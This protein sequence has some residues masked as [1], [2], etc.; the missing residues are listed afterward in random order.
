MNTARIK[1]ISTMVIFGTI[2]IFVRSIP[3]SS[4]II[5]MVRGFVGAAF[6]LILAALKKKPISVK[7]IKANLK[8]LILSGVFIGFN[9]ILLF[10]AYRFTTVATA[11]LCYYFAPI[12]VVLA[13]HFMKTERMTAVKGVCIA[14]A[15]L[16][17]VFVSGVI[18]GGDFNAAGIALGL[19]AAALYA[20]VILTNKRLK[21]I[22]SYDSTIVQ[23]SSA[24]IILVPYTLLT[25]DFSAMTV[26]LSSIALLLFVGV[27]NTGLAYNLYFGSIQA[28][29]AQTV[30]IMGYIDPVVAIILSAI[31]LREKMDV[32]SIIGAVLIL[33]SAFCSEVFGDRKKVKTPKG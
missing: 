24:A 7:A 9:W 15:L 13:S 3:M 32:F 11:T 29:K 12:F 22:S 33:G 16:G 26:E 21:N 28:L 30:A 23:L 1:L 8:Y 2:G 31:I 14:V 25:E 10:E 4:S 19:G 20:G 27:V 5:A 18:G 6:L 17:M